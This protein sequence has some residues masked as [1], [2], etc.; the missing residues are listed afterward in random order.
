MHQVTVA[1]VSSW[2]DKKHD[3]CW[4]S[5]QRAAAFCFLQKQKKTQ[6]TRAWSRSRSI[7]NPGNFFMSGIPAIFNSGIDGIMLLY[8]NIDFIVF[9]TRFL[10]F[11]WFFFDF[12]FICFWFFFFLI[13]LCM[14]TEK[15]RKPTMKKEK[16]PIPVQS[17][18]PG[19]K[20]R[21]NPESRQYWPGPGPTKN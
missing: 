3:G 14:K 12:F 8:E 15:K 21:S 2:R 20:I 5:Q 16:I 6:K 7:P 18:N 10:V 19:S 9:T 17:R 13:L 1:P 4:W 11:F